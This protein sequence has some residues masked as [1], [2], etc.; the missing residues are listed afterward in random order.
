MADQEFNFDAEFA[1]LDVGATS[2]L[3][4][5][6]TVRPTVL[7]FTAA[8][9]VEAVS[10]DWHCDGTRASAFE[11]A[12][13]YVRD[14][15]AVAYGL[16]AHLRRCDAG[17]KFMLPGEDRTSA[18]ESL[19]IGMVSSS[20]RLQSHVYPIRRSPGRSSFGT[21]EVS[22]TELWDWCPIGDPWG[23]PFCVGDTVRFIPRDRAVE[24]GSTL[25]NSLVEITR[26][27]MHEDPDNSED[28]ATFLDDLGNGVF[29]VFGRPTNDWARIVL[30]PRT[31]FNP[32]GSLTVDASR[33]ELINAGAPTLEK[34]AA[35]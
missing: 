1:L 24:P 33:V 35:L 15:G 30:R 14:L 27:R 19:A 26:L 3:L 13:R 28:Y 11:D 17:Y 2:S 32:I 23:N 31:V 10:L 21:P 29:D 12:R 7:A 34:V 9:G 6:G 20:G 4:R 22:Q 25:W 16:V 5:S 18:P 8:A